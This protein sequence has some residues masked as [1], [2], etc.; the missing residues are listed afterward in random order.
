MESKHLPVCQEGGGGGSHRLYERQTWASHGCGRMLVCIMFIYH[1][2]ELSSPQRTDLYMFSDCGQNVIQ[3]WRDVKLEEKRRR[4]E[5]EA[6]DGWVLITSM[7]F[8]LV[9]TDWGFMLSGP[10]HW[11]MYVRLR[12]LSVRFLLLFWP[13]RKFLLW[14]CESGSKTDA[15]A[16]P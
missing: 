3:S 4:G 14:L 8:C 9:M 7:F 12:A 11:Y 16:F 5:E 6:A 10:A 1:D 13:E 15:S 2:A